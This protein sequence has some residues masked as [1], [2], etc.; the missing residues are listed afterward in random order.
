MT[1]IASLGFLDES[2]LIS[3]SR[4]TYPKRKKVEDRLIKVYQIAPKM[5]IAF[6]SEHVDFTLEVL[7]RITSFSLKNLNSKKGRFILPYLIRLAN[8]EY[9]KLLKETGIIKPPKMEFLYCGVINKPQMF[10]SY[11]LHEIIKKKGSSFQVP[12]K[13]GRAMMKNAEGIWSLDPPCPILYKQLFPDNPPHPYIYLGYVAGGSGQDI[14]Y[15]IEKEYYK[16]FDWE[17]GMTK[18]IILENIIDDFIKKKNIPTVGGIVQVWRINEKGVRP[19]CYIR[20]Q[21]T[22]DGKERVLRE[23]KFIQGKWFMVDRETGEKLESAP[24]QTSYLDPK[25]KIKVE[26]SSWSTY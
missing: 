17:L 9:Q 16:L 6:T 11:L 8:F 3:D 1:L 4:I 13:I 24:I 19:V 21:Q 14:F 20:K 15:E 18:G 23:L 26:K 22:K 2:Y 12:E 25:K 5:M 7:R 10:S